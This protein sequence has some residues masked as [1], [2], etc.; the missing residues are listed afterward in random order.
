MKTI[1]LEGRIDENH[2]LI[3]DAPTTI[4]PGPVKITVT[5]PDDEATGDEWATAVP[6]AWAADWSDPREDIYSP[7]DGEPIAHRGGA[8]DA[9]R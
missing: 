9:A 4:P 5:V 2:R 8:D 7:N 1:E 3:A 6:H